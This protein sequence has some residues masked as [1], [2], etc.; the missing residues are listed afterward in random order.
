MS[1]VE[2]DHEADKLEAAAEVSARFPGTV[3]AL[4]SPLDVCTVSFGLFVDWRL[5]TSSSGMLEVVTAIVTGPFP[6]TS[7]VTSTVVHLPDRVGPEDPE[8]LDD[9]AGAFA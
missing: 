5:S 6:L 4:K 2:A 1:S 9:A 3:G 7:D 8:E